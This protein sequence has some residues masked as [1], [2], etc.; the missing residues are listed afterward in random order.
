M[1]EAALRKLDRDLPRLDM[2]SAA[3]IAKQQPARATVQRLRCAE[4][5]SQAEIA[6]SA[7]VG[8][9]TREAGRIVLA[10]KHAAEKLLDRAGQEAAAVVASAHHQAS[11]IIVAAESGKPVDPPRQS[12]HSII[13]EV[14]KRHGISPLDITGRS[15]ALP[16][17]EARRAAMIETYLTRL[18]LSTPSIGREFGGR[19]H[20]TV[21]HAV[22]K[23]GVYRGEKKL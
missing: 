19:D 23:A 8:E 11:A 18:D 20:T 14:A 12:V 13:C 1:A 3:L 4:S 6:A 5:R 2:R 22:R 10:A 15:R 16:I 7:L 17:V 9:A 21:L